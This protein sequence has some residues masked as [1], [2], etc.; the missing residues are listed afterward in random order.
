VDLQEMKKMATTMKWRD[1]VKATIP[2][3]GLISSEKIYRFVRNMINDMVFEQS[4]IPLAVVA[5][6]LRN[7]EKVVLTKGS[8]AKAVQASCS[9]PVIFTPTEINGHLLVDGGAT[10]QLPVLTV[11]ETLKAPFVVAVD[12]NCNAMETARLDNMLQIAIHFVA[13]MARRNA[14][15]EKQFA[16]V[17]IEVD[18][19]GISLID[20]HKGRLLI[21]RGRKAAEQKIDE[22]KEKIKSSQ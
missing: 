15:M 6:N 7:G 12:V 1:M 17:V 8:V 4:K 13:L 19:K 10:S 18:A 20:L 14:L 2:R 22:I 21:D 5:S 16:N 11:K 3:R 9:L